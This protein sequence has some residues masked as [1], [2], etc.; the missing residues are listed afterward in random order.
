M[1]N[2]RVARITLQYMF[3]SGLNA[4]I[5]AEVQLVVPPHKFGEFGELR[6]RFDLKTRLEI[7]NLQE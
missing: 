6:E 3:W 7:N 4:A 1:L 2:S 5:G